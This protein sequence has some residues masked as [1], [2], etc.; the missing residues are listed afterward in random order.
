MANKN[1]L[2]RFVDKGQIQ[3]IR[4]DVKE[5]KVDIEIRDWFKVEPSKFHIFKKSYA[6][7]SNQWN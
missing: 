6:E 3:V 1:V 5:E 2:K 7:W 4:F